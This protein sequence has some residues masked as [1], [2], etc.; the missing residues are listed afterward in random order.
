ML[1]LL[2]F[3]IFFYHE[4]NDIVTEI[5][6][7]EG[8]PTAFRGLRIAHISDLHGKTFGD[9]NAILV[10]KV[11]DLEPDIIAIT[12]DMM[13]DV[14]QF[15]MFQSL[16]ESLVDIAPT[17][18]VTGNHEW[19]IGIVPEIKEMLTEV[20]VIV[21]SN[22]YILFEKDGE[23]LA[24]L[25]AD[26]ENGY[27]DQKTLLELVAEVEENEGEDCYTL[28]LSHRNNRYETYAAAEIDLTLCGHAHGGQI[29]LPFTDGLIGPQRELFPS[30]TAGLYELDYG[31]LYVS[32]GLGDQFPAFRL[33]NKP[34]LP[35][36]I[37][38]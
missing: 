24:L 23:K 30:Y 6:E 27:A 1:I 33:W 35:L 29:R 22:E 3:S 38:S 36:L 28:L 17:Y 11:R 16:A 10:E 14:D 26:D 7:I 2:C 37:L 9:D 34:D 13:D 32:R 25:G 8:T 12:G 20:G 18:Y 5:V 4:Q 19:A 21:L 15:S 31:L